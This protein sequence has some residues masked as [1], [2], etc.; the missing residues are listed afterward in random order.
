MSHLKY[1][2]YEGAGEFAR[3]HLG[4][5]Q[6]VRVGDRVEISGQGGWIWQNN[7]LDFSD[8]VL[9]QIDQAFENVDKALQAGGSKGWEQVFRVN[10]YHLQ[11]TPEV[12][13]RMSENYKKWMPNHKPIWT[14]IGVKELG[15][16]NMAVEIEVVAHD[17]EGVSKA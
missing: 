16:P 11:I 3:D 12:T 4:Y 7:T 17:P 1:N 13:K 15:A 6:V 5:N 2:V 10:S 8:D 14:Q 9:E